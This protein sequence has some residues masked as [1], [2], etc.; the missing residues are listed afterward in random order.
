MSPTER[1]FPTEEWKRWAEHFYSIRNILMSLGEKRSLHKTH[2]EVLDQY[3][4]DDGTAVVHRW[5]LDNY[6]DSMLM[7]LRRL[8]DSRRGTFSLVNFLKVIRKGRHVIRLDRFAA[9]WPREYQTE[10]EAF[11]QHIY[12]RF[13][14]DGRTF[15]REKIEQDIENLR[16][17]HDD[18]LSYIN[19]RVAHT[20]ANSTGG[21]DAERDFGVD[22]M[23]LDR[24]YDEVTAT[25]NKYFALFEPGTHVDFTPVL[26]AGY[27]QAFA[28][29]FAN[30]TE[31][32]PAVHRRVEK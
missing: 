25:F 24:L 1:S 28:R 18:L 20:G 31:N 21:F 6:A 32:P 30:C 8:V 17:N 15:D 29:M 26:P 4:T 16:E 14:S 5:M 23:D 19:E 9:L 27:E 2:M 13:S 11:R 7:G 10:S 22:W 12:S 3:E